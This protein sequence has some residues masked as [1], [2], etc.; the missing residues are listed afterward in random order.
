MV[1]TRRS[2]GGRPQETPAP[3]E[4]HEPAETRRSQ[5][6]IDRAARN[7]A[8]AKSE[9]SMR[10][11]GAGGAPA[12]GAVLPAVP[13]GRALQR[14]TVGRRTPAATKAAEAKR[15]R[16]EPQLSG[17]WVAAGACGLG[18]GR[19]AACSPAACCVMPAASQNRQP[20][21][22]PE[23]ICAEHLLRAP[24]PRSQ[25]PAKPPAPAAARSRAPLQVGQAATRAG[26]PHP[27]MLRPA[28]DEPP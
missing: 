12:A 9:A 11:R 27:G 24:W 18:A 23:L 14:A 2:S 22:A 26:G 28:P 5:R 8:A 1:E 7:K 4:P 3:Q 17:L 13:P 6:L 15:Q 25:P 16:R 20:A 21:P 19:L 10:R